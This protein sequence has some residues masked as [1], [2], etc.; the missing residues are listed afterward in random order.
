M[1]DDRVGG[2]SEREGGMQG[3]A[4]VMGDARPSWRSFLATASLPGFDS[5]PS[6]TWHPPFITRPSVWH[7]LICLTSGGRG[8]SGWREGIAWHISTGDPV[9]L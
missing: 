3:T 1:L 9:G 4:M 8:A 2:T 5:A 7:R 6:H